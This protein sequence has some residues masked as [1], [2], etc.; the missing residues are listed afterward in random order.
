MPTGPNRSRTK[1]I[2]CN[3]RRSRPSQHSCPSAN[4]P[5]VPGHIAQGE[6]SSCPSPPEPSTAPACGKGSTCRPQRPGPGSRQ[7]PDAG[8]LGGLDEYPFPARR[9]ETSSG[10]SSHGR[11]GWSLQGSQGALTGPP[12]LGGCRRNRS[13]TQR[14]GA[15]R[16]IH[17]GL[18]M[19]VRSREVRGGSRTAAAGR[20]ASMADDGYLGGGGAPA[21]PPHHVSV[22]RLPGQQDHR[23]EDGDQR[24]QSK[25]DACVGDRPG[26]PHLARIGLR[27]RWPGALLAATAARTAP[28][29][30]MLSPLHQP[31][32]RSA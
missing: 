16:A 8:G 3:L 29:I 22:E 5:A 26:A 2:C 25:G 4:K 27:R 30:V 24:P 14:P 23:G 15:V 10:H 20:P 18:L 19:T 31:R 1:C 11:A 12:P 9:K 21:H 7:G 32:L 13:L 6:P 28:P 17:S